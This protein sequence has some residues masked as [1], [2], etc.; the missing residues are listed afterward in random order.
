MGKRNFGKIYPIIY[1]LRIALLSGIA[2]IKLM[3]CLDATE[4]WLNCLTLVKY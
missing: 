1:V 2:Q 4:K 3:A